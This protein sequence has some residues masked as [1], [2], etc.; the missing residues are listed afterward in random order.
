MFTAILVF[1]AVTL[2]DIFWASYI[3]SIAADHM[4]RSGLFSAAII[5]TGGFTAIE[6]VQN[7]W[8]LLPA[9]LGAF[10]GT[11]ITVWY[12]KKNKRL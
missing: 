9:A 12:H 6:Y 4:W 3:K 5:V 11:V 8:M 10:V 7:H 1:F 2:V